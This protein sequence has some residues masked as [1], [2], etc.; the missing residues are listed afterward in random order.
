MIW[1]TMVKNTAFWGRA[2]NFILWLPAFLIITS[3]TDGTNVLRMQKEFL[4]VFY[5]IELFRNGSTHFET[6][7]SDL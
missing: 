5:P 3:L 6:P 1:P 7:A 2:G 4:V